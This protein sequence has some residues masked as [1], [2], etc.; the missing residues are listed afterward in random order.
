MEKYSYIANSEAAYI[1]ELYQKFQQ[2]PD[3]VDVSWQR[4]FE[5]FEFSIK[6]GETK[7]KANGNGAEIAENPVLANHTRKEMEVVHLIRGYRQRGHLASQTNPLG[8]R[9]NRYPQLDLKDFNLSEADLNTVFEA[10]IE[11]F[12]RAATLNEIVNALQKVYTGKDILS[13]V[14]FFFRR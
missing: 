14:R 4:F 11:V 8:P 9:K 6:Y 10:G 1:E 3:S 2:Q 7:P 5:G 12:G 13:P